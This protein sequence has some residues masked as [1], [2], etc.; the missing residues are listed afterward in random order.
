ML[1]VVGAYRHRVKVFLGYHLAV[2]GVVVRAGDFP[3]VKEFSC[4]AGDEIGARRDLYVVEQLVRL[5]VRTCD[6]ARSDKAYAQLAVS[7]YVVLY[8]CRFLEFIKI[9]V[10][11]E[12]HVGV[13]SFSD[14][15]CIYY[16]T[17]TAPR[18]VILF[19]CRDEY[20]S[21]ANFAR[22]A[23]IYFL[24]KYCLRRMSEI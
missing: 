24:R 10:L 17:K 18:Q 7:F 6:A 11:Y 23:R 22:C 19:D 13:S 4:L 8:L 15:Y 16:K 2:V 20:C 5:D 1:T 3:V 12:L 14:V 21:S 9:G